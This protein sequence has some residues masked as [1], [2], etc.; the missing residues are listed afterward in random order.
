MRRH[1]LVRT[2]LANVLQWI[3]ALNYEKKNK[4]QKHLDFKKCPPWN[5]LIVNFEY[6]SLIIYKSL[7]SL[8][9]FSNIA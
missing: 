9:H 6:Q 8:Y 3:I 2:L 4:K 5:K 7:N 1:I